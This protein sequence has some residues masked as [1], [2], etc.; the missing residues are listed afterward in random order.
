MKIHS[1][2]FADPRMLALVSAH[3]VTEWTDG[4]IQ[5]GFYNVRSFERRTGYGTWA[6]NTTSSAN[7]TGAGLDLRKLSKE[8][9]VSLMSLSHI[10]ARITVNTEIL[11]SILGGDFDSEKWNPTNYDTSLDEI[12]RLLR[13]RT[14]HAVF[15]I[16]YLLERG[17]NQDVVSNCVSFRRPPATNLAYP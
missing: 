12:A 15:V 11:R 17:K 10:K 14:E 2:L 8:V 3:A 5:T 6:D 7:P 13:R 1:C 16:E 4:E 9:G